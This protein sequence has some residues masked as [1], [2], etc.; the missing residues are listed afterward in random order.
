MLET[1]IL[2]VSDLVAPLQHDVDKSYMTEILPTGSTMV[3]M[4]TAWGAM[5]G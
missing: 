3:T 2:V 4:A 1:L 5:R